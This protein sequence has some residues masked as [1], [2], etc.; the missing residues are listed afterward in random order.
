MRET[1][2]QISPDESLVN[3]CR[4]F[5]PVFIGVEVLTEIQTE[6]SE[7]RQRC[8]HSY[9]LRVDDLLNLFRRWSF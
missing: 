8:Y 7:H 6:K 4:T 3:S 1:I 5:Q 9:N 2:V